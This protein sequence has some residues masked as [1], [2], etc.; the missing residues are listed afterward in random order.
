[1]NDAARRDGLII[2]IIIAQLNVEKREKSES[3]LQQHQMSVPIKWSND[4]TAT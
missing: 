1:M 3:M 4:L 2:I